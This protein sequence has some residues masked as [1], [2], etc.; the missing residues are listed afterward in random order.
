MRTVRS[1]YTPNEGF[2]GVDQFTYRATDGTDFSDPEQVILTVTDKPVVLSEVMASNASTLETMLRSTA[3][4]EFVGQTFTPDWFEVRNLLGQDI[5][6]GGLHVTD[7][8]SE[9][10]KWQFPAGTLVPAN[11]YLVVFASGFDINDSSLD[12]IGSLHT[13]FSLGTTGDFLGITTF[14]GVLIDDLGDELPTQRTHITYGLNDDRSATGYF[15]EPTPGTANGGTALSGLVADT[16]FDVDRG[17][18]DEP[19]QLTIST[20]T[21]EAQIRYTL[22]GTIPN[23]SSTAYA[24]PLTIDKTTTIRAR[25]FKDGMVTTN[26]DTQSYFF[27]NDVVLQDAQQTLD[28]GFADDWRGTSPDYGL[29]DEDQLPYIAGDE[30]MSLEDAREVIKGSLSSLP[31]LS[32]VLNTDDLF[33]RDTGIYSNASRSGKDW[34]RATSV[35]LIHPDGTEGFQIDSGI[36]IQGGAF[37]GFGL[38]KKKSFRFLF[39]TEYGPG[40]LEYP[41]FG[42]EAATQFDTLTLRMEANDGWQWA[43]AGNQPVYARDQWHRETQLAMGSPAPHGRNL[44]VYINGFYWGMYNIVER[45]DESFAENYLGVE[46]PYNWDGQNSGT[47]TNSDGDTYRRDRGRDVWRD[48][49]RLT[50]DIRSADTEEERTAFYMQTIGKNPDGTDNPDFPTLVDAVNYSDYLIANYYG[51]NADWPRKNYYFGRENTPDSEGF[52]FF[53]WD[54]EWSLFLRSNTGRGLVT[55]P[56]G[57]AAPWRGL[58]ESAEFRLLFAD[59]VHKHLFNGGALYVDPDNP[60]WDP[61]HPERNLP[62]KRWT[63]WTDQIYEGLI[64]ESARW[65]D[66]HRSRPYVRHVEWQGE[67]DRIVERWFPERTFSL[68]EVFREL[69]LYP[70]TE[71][72]RVWRARWCVLATDRCDLERAGR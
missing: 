25:A 26:T 65:G 10:T 61:E 56:A 48:L 69:D 42:S 62:A 31:T 58:R 57:V 63:E 54:A 60:D 49:T 18:F 11:G 72:P 16:Q 12:L 19:F 37:R 22:D 20:A 39:K 28:A 70:P 4:E 33:D 46:N 59:R 36:R 14:D 30:N 6:I 21:E 24:G 8:A 29:D 35:E 44:Q 64:A 34:E 71:A 3:D 52:K 40:K 55:D 43:G 15:L 5:D 27:L 13:N 51:G 66:Q 50:G 7:D 38:T 68:L 17:F 67:N 47:A 9:P 53:L 1:S 23:E 2:D 32:I 45:P 41:L